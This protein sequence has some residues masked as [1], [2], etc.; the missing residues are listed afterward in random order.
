ME[1]SGSDPAEDSSSRGPPHERARPI[2][3]N[4]KYLYFI[5]LHLI[6]HITQGRSAIHG[7]KTTNY[8]SYHKNLL[9]TCLKGNVEKFV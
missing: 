8:F 7:H 3:N 6:T 4:V 1:V 2:T 9:K 5:I